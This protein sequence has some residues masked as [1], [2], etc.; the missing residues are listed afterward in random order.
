MNN[1]ATGLRL[2]NP[3]ILSWVFSRNRPNRNPHPMKSKANYHKSHFLAAMVLAIALFNVQPISV[4]QT[5]APAFASDYSFVDLGAAP[6]V[7][8]NYGGLTL[9]SSDLNTLL[10]GGAA[11]GGAGAVYAIGV[12]RDSFGHISGFSGTASL[13]STAP[14]IDGGL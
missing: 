7:P 3:R 4:A 9:V 14:N 13:F 1:P 5:I 2:R 11:N 6:G 12:T 10:L 8:A